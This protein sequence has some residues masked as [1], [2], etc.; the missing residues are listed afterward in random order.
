MRENKSTVGKS[1]EMVFTAGKRT[2]RWENSI[3][4]GWRKFLPTDKGKR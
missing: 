3:L 1:K 4:W 2:G